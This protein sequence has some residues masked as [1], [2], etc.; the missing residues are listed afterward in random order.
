MLTH[1]THYFPN[2]WAR[3]LMERTLVPV[4]RTRL[5][6]ISIPALRRKVAAR[7]R[8]PES[9]FGVAGQALAR[10]AVSP[11]WRF[12]R[13]SSALAVPSHLDSTLARLIHQGCA[14]RLA[15]VA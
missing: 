12:R 6:L 13:L 2:Y 11:T 1:L 10:A 3:D 7:R 8:R 15:S 5:N 9:P 14:E 4:L